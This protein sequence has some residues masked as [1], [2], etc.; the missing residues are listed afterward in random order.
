MS[1]QSSPATAC[2][3]QV[4]YVPPTKATMD[5]LSSTFSNAAVMFGSAISQ[6][7][8]AAQNQDQANYAIS[9]GTNAAGALRSGAF[10]LSGS[11][12]QYGTMAGQL[13]DSAAQV[14]EAAANPGSAQFRAALGAAKGDAEAAANLVKTIAV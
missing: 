8:Y 13:A 5:G 12:P 7:Q 10:A 9:N 3:P 14:I 1:I 2:A 4:P 6:Q 11:L